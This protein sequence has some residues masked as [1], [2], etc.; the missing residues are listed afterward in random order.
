MT[1]TTKQDKLF[2]LLLRAKTPWEV[3]P[4]SH[5]PVLPGAE[6]VIQRCLALR[7]LELPVGEWIG[8]A[9]KREQQNL[10]QKALAMLASNQKDELRHDK[11]LNIAFNSMKLTSEA[12]KKDIESQA[13]DIL[14][15][16]L[17]MAD[18]YHPAAVAFVGEA[19]VFIPAL[20][21]FRRLGNH[22]LGM[23]SVEVSRD[24]ALHLRSHKE[25][26]IEI[27]GEK[28]GSEL[29][30]L[31]QDT[32]DWVFEPL[33]NSG[34]PGKYGKT[35]TYREASKSLVYNGVAPELDDTRRATQIA[36]FECSNNAL[37]TY[38]S[39]F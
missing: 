3:M 35:R 18:K 29:D 30:S 22:A 34:I 16:W 39:F 27:G 6:E 26:G 13:K 19:G 28:I 7:H 17:E 1:T 23:I 33:S 14:N 15:R 32:L 38:Q 5:S 2:N 25:I 36:F 21:A 20:T 8:A 9:S 4:V 12:V 24:E 37:P 31:R 11:Q 10:G